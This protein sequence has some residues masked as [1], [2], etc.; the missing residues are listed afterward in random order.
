MSIQQTVALN[1][2][3]F[4]FS[5]DTVP[6]LEEHVFTHQLDGLKPIYEV[7]RTWIKTMN[8]NDN[9]STH[10]GVS[11]S[12]HEHDVVTNESY[13]ISSGQSRIVQFVLDPTFT[14]AGHIS[15]PFG[16]NVLNAFL[17][18]T[19]KRSYGDGESFY[20]MAGLM[21]NLQA[22]MSDL[23][24]KVKWRQLVSDNTV[25]VGHSRIFP[26]EAVMEYEG[27]TLVP[28]TITIYKP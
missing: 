12:H 17:E 27:K 2:N 24:G 10:L 16:R 20:D 18:S 1:I 7:V 11:V 4:K 9:I 6:F 26:I 28:F 5:K 21:H 22:L 23:Q 19:K 13:R 15:T 8:L 25:D 3:D 14:D